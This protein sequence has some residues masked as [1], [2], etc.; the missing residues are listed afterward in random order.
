MWN[1]K[2]LTG[3]GALLCLAI[4]AALFGWSLRQRPAVTAHASWGMQYERQL[5]DKLRQAAS[6]GE[7]LR[8]G[9]TP[10]VDRYIY[11]FYFVN[12]VLQRWTTHDI[13]VPESELAAVDTMETFRQLGDSWYVTN[14]C[15][16]DSV[17]IVT[18]ILIKRGYVYENEFL[19]PRVSPFATAATVIDVTPATDTTDEAGMVRSTSGD[20][21]FTLIFDD[22]TL[23]NRQLALRWIALA[24]LI[25]ALLLAPQYRNTIPMRVVVIGLLA[26]SRYGIFAVEDFFY[27]SHFYLFAPSLYADS[28]FIPSLGSLLLHALFLFLMTVMAA[29]LLR[30][31]TSRDGGKHTG[32][33]VAVLAA[34]GVCAWGIH[35]TWRSLILNSTIPLNL[36]QLDQ[37]TPYTAAA[38]GILILL[39][40]TLFLLV[41]A[42]VNGLP[43]FRR[44]IQGMWLCY[45][46][47]A[48][49]YA[50]LSLEIYGHRMEALQARAWANKYYMEHDPTAEFYLN[51]RVT[52]A[53]V[54]DTELAALIASA[55][56]VDH[57][58]Y[59]IRRRH[60]QG[61]LQHYDLQL[62]ICPYA[63]QLHIDGDDGEEM[64]CRAF[65]ERE[66]RLTG[67]RLADDS[68]FY[69]LL[70]DNGRN[71]YLGVLHYVDGT[72]R[73]VD[74]FLELDSQL[75]S[76]GEGYP[77]LLIEKS[78]ANKIRM[79][80]GY[81]FAKYA[82]GKL[83]LYHGDFRYPH[84]NR[85]VDGD[86]VIADGYV[87]LLYHFDRYYT[88]VI[89]RAAHTFWRW[90]ILFSYLFLITA[91]GMAALLPAAGLRLR[92]P[93][94]PNTFKR[95]I[96]VLFIAAF[97]VSILCTAIGSIWH[98]IH[99]FR[100]SA[101]IQMEDKIRAV[102]TQLDYD[103]SHIHTIYDA[104]KWAL[105]TTLRQLS[106]SLR[107]DVNIY[108]MEGQLVTSSRMEVFERRLQS[109]RLHR[110]AFDRLTGGQTTEFVNRERIGNLA[111]NAMY[112][113]YY[114]RAGEPV[115]YVNIPYFSKR[116]QDIRETSAVITTI[117]NVY[118]LA[119]IA[120]LLL[121]V[122]LANR[123][124]R[125]LEIVR[126]HMQRL[127]VTKKMDYI[128]Y[129]E[130][131]EL[132]DLIRA[133]NQMIVALEE[134]TRQLAQSERE[135]AWREM[136]RQIAH[137]IKNPLT[138][139]Q[140][141]IQHLV[142]LKKEKASDWPVRF[143]ELAVAL[144]EQIDTL[145][146]TASEFSDFARMTKASPVK[147]RLDTLLHELR[148]LFDVYATIRFEWRNIDAPATVVAHPDLL[149]RVF[150]NLL[151]NAVQ[152]VQDK[153][154]GHIRITLAA[155][156]DG[157]RV[158]IEDNGYGVSDSL[159]PQ[160]FTL[161][162]TTK[163]SGSGLGLAISKKILEHEGGHIIYSHSELGGACF[164]VELRKA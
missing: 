57:V 163:T 82:G 142:R 108:D 104:D 154:E 138:P 23:S 2:Q 160:L 93:M 109:T 133:Y 64:D 105:E 63:T 52:P 80:T 26:L 112:A 60:L 164:M 1:K 117:I 31:A 33:R 20:P 103:L 91:A 99:R 95:K 5:H 101:M 90:A 12:G 66:I 65:F 16:I 118:I 14:A 92:W 124:L 84:D 139:M 77:E 38:Y 29:P 152:A 44:R 89:S 156:S 54:A 127:D 96:A 135:S 3:I 61:Y 131:D 81:S 110:T 98:S 158:S 119:L 70:N 134:S 50:M 132:G 123:L 162:F 19:Q 15:E 75:L 74:V 76:G 41:H 9:A 144:L 53:I 48:A 151:T 68:P 126:R 30:Q 42:S 21:L 97:M 11:P 83:I 147:V 35:Y 141:S 56:P 149:S 102:L 55:T 120:A 129:D 94:P 153:P 36:S 43:L 88:I 113:A 150:L 111:F 136:A 87:H 137:E 159:R 145:A 114:N 148:P 17:K 22:E 161:N 140:L 79:P 100:E 122:A 32:A 46:V 47:A 62:T 4:A 146:K 28:S 8:V 107:I 49:C 51:E 25:A 130:K 86:K 67:E 128:R 78:M 72:G 10:A 18:A 116:M 125:P 45:I 71:S 37:L 157:Y 6:A 73:D 58:Q 13:A 155:C 34:A 59:Y 106:N 69:C 7:Q 40:A 115:A 85:F 27:N 121:G 24:W 143:D 39:L